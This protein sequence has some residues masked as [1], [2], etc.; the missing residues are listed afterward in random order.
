M[1]ARISHH[2]HY[3]WSNDNM[4]IPPIPM[5]RYG[6]FRATLPEIISMCGAC[7]MFSTLL[8]MAILGMAGA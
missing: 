7:I 3:H 4:K 1:A 6:R 2:N 8:W 5:R